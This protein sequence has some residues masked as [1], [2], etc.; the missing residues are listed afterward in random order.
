MKQTTQ[1]A[2]IIGIISLVGVVIIGA[3]ILEATDHDAS[4]VIAYALA[5]IPI[6]IVQLYQGNVGAKANEE[7]KSAVNGKLTAQLDSIKDHVSTEVDRA[8][9]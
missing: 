5:V 2:T 6:L 4:R 9:K 7:I 1:I 8:K 3:V